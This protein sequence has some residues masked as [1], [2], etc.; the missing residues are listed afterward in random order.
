MAVTAS[1]PTIGTVIVTA[2]VDAINPCAIGVMILLVSTLI[3]MK[4]DTRKMLR[5]GLLYIFFV[6]MTYLTFGLGMTAFVSEIPLALAEYISLG[7][8]IIVIGAGLLEIKDFFWYGQGFSLMIPQKRAKQ[9]H[10]YINKISVP[11]A[12]FLGVFVA[13]V[14]LPCTGGPYLAITLLLAQQGFNLT[15]F[16]LLLVYNLIFVMPLVIILILALLGKNIGAVKQWK[17]EKRK[18]MRYIMG[19]IMIALGWLLML[20]AN[21]T[22]NLN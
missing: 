9:I 19:L 8:G 2:A 11:G 7:V 12:I 6:F 22:I 21:G 4:K 13:A 1:L 20:I 18:Y 10:K 3:G 5:I 14:E 15:A 16:L 17:Q